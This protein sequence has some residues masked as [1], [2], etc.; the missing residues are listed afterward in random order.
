MEDILLIQRRRSAGLLSLLPLMDQIHMQRVFVMVMKAFT[1]Q[2]K[3]G[4]KRRNDRATD[5]HFNYR[6]R[7]VYCIRA[8]PRTFSKWIVIEM[9][10]L[11]FTSLSTYMLCKGMVA[12]AFC[13]YTTSLLLSP[14]NVAVNQVK[15]WV[16]DLQ[17]RCP[18]NGR[19]TYITP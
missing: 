10:F 15:V 6:R 19:A 13:R 9:L 7:H 2:Q 3:N 4:V 5:V 11:V 1:N 16:E 14:W 17:C 12:Y 18:I 8:Q